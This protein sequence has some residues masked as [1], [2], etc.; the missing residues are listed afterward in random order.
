MIIKV[1]IY[2]DFASLDCPEDI[3]LIVE[4]FN[5]K[6]TKILQQNSGSIKFSPTFKK[7][8]IGHFSVD[9]II[10]RKKALDSLRTSK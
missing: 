8:L 9:N 5:L 6:F 3:P 7:Q 2:L 10:T 1:P 4:E